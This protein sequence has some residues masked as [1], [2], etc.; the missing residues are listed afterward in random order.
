MKAGVASTPPTIGLFLG[1]GINVIDAKIDLHF[2]EYKTIEV[3]FEL[4][5]DGRK[6]AR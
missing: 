1:H 4:T 5:K 2:N 6:K 3:M